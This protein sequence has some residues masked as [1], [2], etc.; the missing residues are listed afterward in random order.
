MGLNPIWL[1]FFLIRRGNSE[2]QTNTKD[3]STP[4]K[5]HMR[6]QQ[7]DRHLQTG[8]KPAYTLIL[9]TQPPEIK[10]NCCCLR[11]LVCVII[12]YFPSSFIELR[13]TH[14]IVCVYVYIS[15]H[16]MRYFDICM[17]CEK[18]TTIQLINTCITSLVTSS[19]VCGRHIWDPL[20]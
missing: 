1:V 14:K 15:T 13:L 2:A 3:T 4:R 8:T 20:S 9:D 5:D 10:I 17:H 6:T 12:D 16:K 19:C 11:H 18:I 7:G